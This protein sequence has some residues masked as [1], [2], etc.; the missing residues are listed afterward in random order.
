[1]REKNL[2]LRGMRVGEFA[3]FNDMRFTK[4]KETNSSGNTKL[5][6]E[7]LHSFEEEELEDNKYLQIGSEQ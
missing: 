2:V 1:M 4:E 3:Q 6:I 5:R 7:E